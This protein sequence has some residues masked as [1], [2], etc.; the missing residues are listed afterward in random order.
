M[1]DE[2][3]I[4]CPYIKCAAG[5]GLAGNRYCFLDGDYTDSLCG[6]FEDEEEFLKKCNRW[7]PYQRNIIN[8]AVK[9]FRKVIE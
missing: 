2:P 7:F 4:S 3:K 9:D 5:M 8:P 6:C 1:Q